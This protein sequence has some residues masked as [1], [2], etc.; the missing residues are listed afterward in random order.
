LNILDQLVT[1]YIGGLR[2]NIQDAL[3]LYDPFTLSEAHQKARQIEKKGES[4]QWNY[5]EF[6][7]SSPCNNSK[8]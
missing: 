7:Y 6:N 3:S 8:G 1:R 2:Q 5:L 4:P